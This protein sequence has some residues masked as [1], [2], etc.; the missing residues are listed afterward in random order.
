MTDGLASTKICI[1]PKAASQ[2]VGFADVHTARELHPICFQRSTIDSGVPALEPAAAA[3]FGELRILEGQ[4][5]S[6]VNARGR[7]AFTSPYIGERY[8]TFEPALDKLRSTEHGV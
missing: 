6:Y 8:P 5:P 7:R 2:V 4:V 1:L 3:G